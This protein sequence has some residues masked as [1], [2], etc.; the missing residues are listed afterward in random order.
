MREIVLD[1]ETTGFDPGSGHRIVE[2]GCVE[3][4]DH[5]PTGKSFQRY[6][7]PE[8]DVPEEVVRVHGLTGEFLKDKPRFAEVADAFLEFLANS[9]SSSTMRASIFVSSMPSSTA[10]AASPS[11]P[12]GPSTR[13]KS[14]RPSFPACVILSTNC[15]SA[16][17][18]I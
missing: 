2:I 1:T 14:P 5:F 11:R 18:S 4:N 15:V 8:R 3:L 16:S 9:R 12:P 10:S 17:A 13:S 7:N 6:L